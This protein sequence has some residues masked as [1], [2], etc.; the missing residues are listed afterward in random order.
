MSES[1]NTKICGCEQGTFI[2]CI[3]MGVGLGMVFFG[4]FNMFSFLTAGANIV[5]EF[6]FFFYQM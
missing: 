5:L 1:A 2:K 6:G 4:F 3:N